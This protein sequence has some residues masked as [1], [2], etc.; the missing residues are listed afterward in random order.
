[1]SLSPKDFFSNPARLP[2][3]PKVVTHLVSSLRKEDVSNR[4]IHELL[5]IEPVLVAKTLRLANSA[6]FHSPRTIAS[7]EDALQMLG[8]DM[9][10]NLVVGSAVVGA[11]KS[12]PGIDLP[13]FWRFSLNTACAARWIAQQA[14]LEDELA[15]LIGLIH[16]LGQLVMHAARLEEI[17]NLD[18]DIHPLALA[19]A[20]AERQRFGFDH[21]EVGAELALHW[22]FPAAVA[23]TIRRVPDPSE[24]Q[25]TQALVAC[26]HLA[27]WR[28]R[29]DLFRWDAQQSE[30]TCPRNLG[31]LLRWPFTW[32]APE[33]VLMRLPI[34]GAVPMPALD[35]LTQGLESMLVP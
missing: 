2:V 16:A 33:R 3:A 20:A 5:G 12:A 24:A 13:S 23:E 11:F 29:V 4:E 9:V 28:A 14:A 22:N 27:A 1:M 19:R 35:V 21:G 8:F 30:S 17:R 7:I 31:Q 6:Y 25:D 18:Q 34:E 32:L 26:V 10:R 15:F